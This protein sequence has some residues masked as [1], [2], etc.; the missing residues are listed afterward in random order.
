MAVLQLWERK[1]VRRASMR[2]LSVI[3]DNRQVVVTGVEGAGRRFFAS[4]YFPNA[5]PVVKSI[6]LLRKIDEV[7]VVV[8]LDCCHLQNLAE[9]AVLQE[10]SVLVKR[11]K[12]KTVRLLLVL[13]RI[14]LV[15][16][17]RQNR[18]WIEAVMREYRPYLKKI[19]CKKRMIIAHSN[20]AVQW[21]RQALNG[22]IGAEDIEDLGH[23]LSKTGRRLPKFIS[24]DSA[25]AYVRSHLKFFQMLSGEY[26]VK[27]FLKTRKNN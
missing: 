26:C 6:R 15:C 18:A 5:N 14:D 9:A 23:L 3:D 1:V 12:A 27:E 11:W 22:E 17:R 13:G 20:L 2:G 19:K 25:T 21:V 4:L 24:P 8:I 7:V 10:V 16:T